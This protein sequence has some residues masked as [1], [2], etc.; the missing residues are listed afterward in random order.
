MHPLSLAFLALLAVPVVTGSALAQTPVTGRV[1]DAESGETLPAATALAVRLDPDSTRVGVAA[2]VEGR[3]RLALAPGRWRLRIS[4]AGFA[5]DVREITV[6]GVPVALGDVALRSVELDEVQVGALRQR[7]EV[8]GDT[9]AYN[10]AA[11]AVNPDASVEDLVSKLPGV[12][13]QEGEVQAQG[14]RVQRVLV[15]GEEFFGSDPTAAL[16][17]LPAEVVQEIQV[18]ERASDQAR[19]TGVD[20]GEGEL[21]INVVTRPD[22]R[23]GQF[24]RLFAGGGGGTGETAPTEARYSAGGAV[25]AFQG[26]RRISVIGIANN[27]NDQNFAAEDL[28]GV[29]ESGDGGGGRRG[30]RGGRG[31]GTYLVGEQPGVTTTTALGVNYT[32]RFGSR[33]RVQGSAFL[34]RTGTLADAATT[35]DYVVGDALSYLEDDDG[36]RTNTNLRFSGRVEAELDDATQLTVRPRLSLQSYDNASL[37]TAQTLL[38]GALTGLTRNGSDATSTATTAALDVLLRRRFATNGRSLSLGLEGGLDGQR[39]DTDQ[40]VLTLAYDGGRADTTS[41]YQRQIDT[42]AGG[43]QLEASLRY[44]EPLAE[45]LSLQLD[46]S[47]SVSVSSGDADAFRFDPATGLF[48]VVDSSFTSVSDQRVVTHRGGADLSYRTDRVRLRA[49]LDAEREALAYDQGGPRPFSVDRTTV[50]LLP[51]ANARLELTDNADLDLRYRARTRTPSVTQLRDVV[52]DTNALL[53]TAGNPDLATAREHTVDLRFRSTQPEA[54]SVVFG[55]VQL[56]AATDYVGQSVTVAG[57][58][59]RVVDGVTLAPGAQL[60]APVNLDGY[61]RARAFGTLGR[62]ISALKVN[63][64]AT[65]G[66]TYTRTPSLYN[67]VLNRADALALDGRVFLGTSASERFDA[68]VGYGVSWTGVQNSS[69]ASADDTYLR[70][71]GEARLTWLPAGGLT[72]TSTLDLTAYTGL[73][74]GTVPTTAVWNAALGYKLLTDDRAEVRLSVNDLLGQNTGVTQTL[75]DTYVE[76]SQAQA[77]GRTVMLGVSYRLRTFGAAD[78]IPEPPDEGRDEGRRGRRPDGPPPDGA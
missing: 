48:S 55:S 4:F 71:R 16:R 11:Y 40:D 56:A 76:T 38:D 68:S 25:H 61:T 60:T 52:D 27:I 14:E 50:S 41:A 21:T 10:A 1:T 42:G 33:V 49:G 47:P 17:N 2:D 32:D 43:R 8:R 20:D 39:R 54:G 64:N 77:L 31:A 57:A 26:T 28:L 22:R 44:T 18:F 73:D 13:V 36:D 69:R 67:D 24:G 66:A 72:V 51:S 63:A 70:H 19:F 46:Y 53:V 7:V 6:E 62:P 37:L 9:T 23:R 15:D 5:P 29:L 45:R 65:L 74:V 58:D 75:A 35:R 30:G 34:N 59:G 3:F 12:V 78:Q